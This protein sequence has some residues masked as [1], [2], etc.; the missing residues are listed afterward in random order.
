MQP[1]TPTVVPPVTQP[2]N[3]PQ[4][5]TTRAPKWL[6]V[7]VIILFLILAVIVFFILKVFYDRKSP[8]GTSTVVNQLQS[9]KKSAQYQIVS[10][11]ELDKVGRTVIYKGR[12]KIDDAR[13]K[14]TEGVGWIKSTSSSNPDQSYRSAITG[15]F[16][17][18]EKIDKSQD[19]YFLLSIPGDER[20]IKIRILNEPM[21]KLLA[22]P[23]QNLTTLLSVEDLNVMVTDAKDV[24]QGENNLGNMKFVLPEDFNKMFESGD[25]VTIVF[26]RQPKVFAPLVDENSNLVAR[27]V[28]IRRFEGEKEIENEVYHTYPIKATQ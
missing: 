2:T 3:N 9:S 21:K 4:T 7:I 6:V 11:D 1:I 14:S 5:S 20:E 15:Y 23:D 27:S 19:Y 24:R 26:L 8:D 22:T 25:V 10:Q 18:V 16:Q 12:I 17:G 13:R 28:S